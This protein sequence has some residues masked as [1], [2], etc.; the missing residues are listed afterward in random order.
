MAGGV[1]MQADGY[2]QVGAEVAGIKT[3][4]WIDNT[5]FQTF[6][7]PPDTAMASG[8]RLFYLLIFL[9]CF[10]QILTRIQSSHHHS[11]HLKRTGPS[12]LFK[13]QYNEEEAVFADI[14]V[15]PSTISHM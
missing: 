14:L 1:Q 11:Q 3:E 7:S 15:K 13:R 2:I 4:C 10:S 9:F 5:P 6:H 12:P 8:T